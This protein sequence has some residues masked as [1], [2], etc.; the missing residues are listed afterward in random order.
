MKEFHQLGI[1]YFSTDLNTYND[2]KKNQKSSNQPLAVVVLPEIR[3][4]H[5][6]V[7][8]SE[9]D[10]DPLIVNVN[11]FIV[12]HF[13]Q[14]ISR[15]VVQLSPDYTEAELLE[16][17]GKAAIGRN[18]RCLAVECPTAGTFYVANPGNIMLFYSIKS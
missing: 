13:E 16:C 10:T 6:S 4:H 12:W 18:R 8:K 15:N 7:R 11:D 2:K 17:H 1:H 14:N 5:K 9:F 3:F